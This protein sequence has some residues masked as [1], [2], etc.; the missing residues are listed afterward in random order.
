MKTTHKIGIAVVAI[1]IST[2]LAVVGWQHLGQRSVVTDDF[3][4]FSHACWASSM[5]S[6][7]T[8]VNGI[9]TFVATCRD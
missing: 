1:S 7:Q 6:H 8:S 4:A 9:R 3:K 2:I 5:S